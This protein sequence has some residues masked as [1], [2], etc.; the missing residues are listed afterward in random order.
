MEK[1]VRKIAQKWMPQSLKIVLKWSPGGPGERSWNLPWG[2]GKS[3][4][5]GFAFGTSW[6]SWGYPRG[7]LAASIF[8]SFPGRPR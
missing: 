7:L 2:I 4:R 5:F 6:G 3:I 1:Y 8:A